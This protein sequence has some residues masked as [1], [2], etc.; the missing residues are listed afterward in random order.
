MIRH[1]L[2]AGLTA[3]L[4]ATAS[5]ALGQSPPYGIAAPSPYT[6]SPPTPGAL[7]SD[8]QDGRYLLGGTW[9]QRADANNTG[10]AAGYWR[11]VA[12]TAGWRAI[13]VPNAYNAGDF[14]QASMNGSVEWYRRDFTLPPHAFASY[15]PGSAQSWV[16]EFESVDYT[17]TVWLNGHELGSHDGG[18]LPFEFPL[19]DL[20]SGTNQLIVRVDDQRTPAD[21]PPGPGGGW[22]NFGGILDAVYLLP[23]ARADL[24]AVAIRPTLSCAS[25]SSPA[26]H[27]A[28]LKRASQSSGC[29]ASISERA[30]VLNLSSSPQTVSLQGRYG[31]V[32][33]KFGSTT[34]APGGSWT[35]S[36]TAAL[37]NPHLWAPGS[38]YLY[39][40]T[41]TLSDS[42]RRRLGGY[43][44]LS[45]VR[46]ITVSG[47]RLEL[48]GRL[49]DLRGVNLHEQ[50]LSTGAALS[51]AQ[52]AQLIDWVRELGATIIR[53]HY[54][55][56]PELEEMADRDG[57]LLWSEVPV[58]QAGDAY[59]EDPTWRARAL[60]L[61][62][63]NID[64]NQNHPSILLWSIG[65]ELPTPPTAGETAY[66][67]A[68]AAEA[69][70]IDPTR[71]VG[72]AL[73]NWP[74][75]PCEAAYAPLD[76]LGFNEYFGWFDAG[77]G[78]TDDRLELSPYLD[79]LRACYP[80]PAIMVSEFGFGADRAGP[81]EVRG[82]YLYQ[83]N[84]LQFTL[85]VFATKSWLSGAIY[86]PMQDFAAS[87]GYDGSDPLGNPPFVDKGV[88]DQYGNEKPSFALMAQLYG[89]VQQIAP[90]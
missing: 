77:G 53:A 14:T 25:G 7:E 73:S 81:L 60:A 61:L 15:V 31:G 5:P 76:V 27:A 51:V 9:L 63:D 4:L 68:A 19:T 66:I 45:G 88:L 58:Y 64:A 28:S 49:L 82:T 62:A 39:R 12:S 90:P 23:V 87:P 2:M 65:N 3:G 34:I 78:T 74:G 80:S 37:A 69:K 52:Q 59:L 10:L 41:V 21:F 85:G 6:A 8:G 36:A 67:A 86:F 56:D 46:S 1:L 26:R 55:L 11:D 70:S 42:R 43:T 32:G 35:P 16:I 75:V 30:T 72:M 40:A 20:R 24:D 22:W 47:G 57:I 48:N 79:G 13:T 17:A 50:T 29:K 54:P 44:Y 89:Q 18:Y 33:L 84:E 38:P 71:P 83:E